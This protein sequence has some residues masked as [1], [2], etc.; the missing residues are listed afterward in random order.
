LY[1]IAAA[2]RTPDWETTSPDPLLSVLCLQLYLLTPP[3]R[4]KF[5]GTTLETDIIL[6][7]C[8]LFACCTEMK[9]TSGKKTKMLTS[10]GQ[11]GKLLTDGMYFTVP[12]K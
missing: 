5:L 10:E 8:Q 7:H 1:Q 4:T 6:K 9:I 12:P 11:R 2:S 3:P